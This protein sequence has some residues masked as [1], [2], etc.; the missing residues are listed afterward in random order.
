MNTALGIDDYSFISDVSGFPM[1]YGTEKHDETI[2][3]SVN[4]T[5][6]CNFFDLSLLVL[7]HIANLQYWLIA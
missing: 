3:P 1:M 2:F 7:F 4:C 6:A 5:C